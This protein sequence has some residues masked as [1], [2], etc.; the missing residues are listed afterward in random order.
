MDGFW[1]SHSQ[2]LR[3]QPW[4]L[5]YTASHQRL[6]SSAVFDHGAFIFGGTI[7]ARF[8]GAQQRTLTYRKI[9]YAATTSK[10]ILPEG[11]INLGF[12][13]RN[14]TILSQIT[15]PQSSD[16]I[17]DAS[18]PQTTP[19]LTTTEDDNSEEATEESATESDNTPITS[20]YDTTKREPLEVSLNVLV[21]FVSAIQLAGTLSYRFLQSMEQDL[22]AWS[23]VYDEEGYRR[24][25]RLNTQRDGISA[26]LGARY[27]ATSDFS[28]SC[29]LDYVTPS[30]ADT[31][32]AS[33]ENDNLGGYTLSF[34]VEFV[35]FS[36]VRWHLST[37]YQPKQ[38]V[39]FRYD[40]APKDLAKH[41]HIPFDE[42]Q[43]ISLWQEK[44][45]FFLGLAY[46]PGGNSQAA[47][48]S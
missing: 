38:S 48:D 10:V 44:Y 5:N 39:A 25:A 40:Y 27:F 14:V 29:A 11:I 15:L 43:D 18:I 35:T 37:A 1:N 33:I 26:S 28:V 13:H 36:N 8:Y 2:E 6:A 4:K 16:M 24:L 17:V 12:Q 45:A 46:S 41:Q 20:S 34:D 47:D 3:E 23:A 32:Y 42:P 7:G 9:T 22:H 19:T 21:D 30:Y 31:K